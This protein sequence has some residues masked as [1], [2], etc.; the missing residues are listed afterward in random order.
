MTSDTASLFML[1]AVVWSVAVAAKSFQVVKSATNY[2]FAFWDGGMIRM[3]KTLGATGTKVKFVLSAAIAAVCIVSIAGGI[4]T[5]H[6]TKVLI[7][8]L[9][10]SVIN[11]F[12]SAEG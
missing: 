9:V 10:A 4:A 6:G 8:L 11:D 7:A 12:V 5:A 3:G 2:T 1:L